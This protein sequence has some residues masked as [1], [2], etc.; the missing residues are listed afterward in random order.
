[1]GAESFIIAGVAL[2]AVCITLVISSEKIL[3]SPTDKTNTQ[4]INILKGA[5]PDAL[6]ISSTVD[7]ICTLQRKKAHLHMDIQNT[8]ALLMGSALLL[9][10]ISFESVIFRENVLLDGNITKV[11]LFTTGILFVLSFCY[12]LR[13]VVEVG[14]ITKLVPIVGE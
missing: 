1:M 14:R 13:F 7:S 6:D 12:I 2:L 8:I 10:A 11:M 4:I 3:K 9:I 5:N